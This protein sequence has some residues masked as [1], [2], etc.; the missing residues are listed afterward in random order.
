MPKTRYHTH[1][2]GGLLKDSVWAATDGIITTFAVVA[3]STGASLT[4]NIVLILGFANLFADGFSMAV[5]NFLGTES[6]FDYEGIN[7]KRRKGLFSHSIATF[8]AFAVAGFFP[9][10]P[11]VLMLNHPSF[12]SIFVTGAA[13]FIVGILRSMVT[14]KHFIRSGVEMLLIGGVAAGIAFSAGYLV[15]ILVGYQL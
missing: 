1:E 12:I 7:A 10:T 13:L 9:L 2:E 11:F 6:E 4:T 15:R 3:G 14:R 8:F 5:S